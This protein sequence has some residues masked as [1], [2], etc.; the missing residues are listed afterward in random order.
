M[1]GFK[2]AGDEWVA[3]LGTTFLALRLLYAFVRVIWLYATDRGPPRMMS[4]FLFLVSG[5]AVA[6]LAVAAVSMWRGGQPWVVRIFTYAFAGGIGFILGIMF[7]MVIETRSHHLWQWLMTFRIPQY[8]EQLHYADEEARLAAATKLSHLG[9][10]ARPAVPE[11]VT[12]FKDESAEVRAAAVLAVLS[13]IP[14]PPDDADPDLVKAARAALT[15]P[16][17]R[18]RAVA[19]AILVRFDAATPAEVL[20]ALCEGLARTGD[21]TP[22]VA[23][24]ALGK[25]GPAATPAIAALRDAA[26]RAEG[27][28][29]AAVAALGK[30]GEPAIPALVEILARGEALCQHIAA[31][32]LGTLGEPARVALPELRKLSMQ[33][34]H[35]AASTAKQAISKLGGDIG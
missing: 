20:P 23:A 29:Y 32:S 11:L 13:T 3:V 5:L 35:I 34:N 14:D 19:A 31:E 17:V 2:L 4:P 6:A 12:L 28:N 21:S 1:F 18:V 16:D 8:R 33:T 27:Q 26:L 15:D 9:D 25:L 10:R 22:L 24:E 7:D 30:I